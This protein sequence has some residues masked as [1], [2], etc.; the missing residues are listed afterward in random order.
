MEKQMRAERDKR[1]AILNA[2]GFKASQILTAEGEKQSAILR[3]EG[4]AQAAVVRADGEA[5]AIAR[6]FKAIHEADPDPKLLAYQYIQSLPAIASGDS[7]KIWVI[8]AELTAAMSLLSKGFTDSG[9]TPPE[10]T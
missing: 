8:P 6:V 2:E 7:N 4:G 5:Q 9:S 10:A 3:A 1:A